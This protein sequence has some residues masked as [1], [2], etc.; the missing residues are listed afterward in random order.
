[1]RK[2][3]CEITAI[4]GVI[5][6]AFMFWYLVFSP[7]YFFLNSVM[8]CMIEVGSDSKETYEFCCERVRGAK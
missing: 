3:L 6:T 2:I 1:M 7:R 8:D 4:L 5:T